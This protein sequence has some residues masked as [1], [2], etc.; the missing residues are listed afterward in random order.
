V[1]VLKGDAHMFSSESITDPLEHEA[2]DDLV[3]IGEDI[4]AWI[5]VDASETSD[6]TDLCDSLLMSLFVG[7]G[8]IS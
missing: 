5:S 7:E 8:K 3:E 2:S 6:R 1:L 4:E